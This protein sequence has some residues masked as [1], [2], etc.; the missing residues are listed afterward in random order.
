MVFE[1]ERAGWEASVERGPDWVFVRLRAGG[2]IGGGA[3][4]A[5]RLLG[6]IR[7]HNVHRVVLEL[8]EVQ[9][10][11]DALF[12]ALTRVGSRIRDDGG[13]VRVCGLSVADIERL[14]AA[15]HADDLPH[16]ESRSAAVGPRCG[17]VS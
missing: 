3:A 7:E 14:R 12:A 6:M 4:L 9:G 5:D 1:R 15:G 13:L 17:A 11:D 8:D 16:F 2:A 10:M